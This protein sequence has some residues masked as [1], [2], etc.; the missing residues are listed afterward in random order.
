MTSSSAEQHLTSHTRK[1]FLPGLPVFQAAWESPVIHSFQLNNLNINAKASD[2]HVKGKISSHL[3]SCR[4]G[5]GLGGLRSHWVC[6]QG[7]P[8]PLI[9]ALVEKTKQT[10]K[11]KEPQTNHVTW[12]AEEQNRAHTEAAPLAYLYQTVSSTQTTPGTRGHIHIH[13]GGAGT[14]ERKSE[15]YTCVSEGQ[16]AEVWLV[17][18][19]GVLLLQVVTV[20]AILTWIEQRNTNHGKQNNKKRLK[21]FT[22]W[23]AKKWTQ[24]DLHAGTCN[25]ADKSQKSNKKGILDRLNHWALSQSELQREDKQSRGA[26]TTGCGVSALLQCWWA[27]SA[28]FITFSYWRSSS[29][30]TAWH[31]EP[32][33]TAVSLKFHV[34]F[35]YTASHKS[36][37]FRLSSRWIKKMLTSDIQFLSMHKH[38]P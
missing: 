3:K 10:T 16:P 24:K 7:F 26:A 32:L 5:K 12:G 30:T 35:K 20:G 9:W 6:T 31:Q 8:E 21:G 13:Q 4:V 22:K 36:S 28:S 27:R 33:T 29:Q 19:V 38:T 23:D 2:F 17:R 18:A 37:L 1:R 25:T 11:P 34:K 14:Q 15:G